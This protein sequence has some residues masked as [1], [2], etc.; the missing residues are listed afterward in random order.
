MYHIG[1][2][3]S[4]C[5]WMLSDV[6]Q[7]IENEFWA[8]SSHISVKNKQTNRQLIKEIIIFLLDQVKVCR[9]EVDLF[10]IQSLFK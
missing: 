6:N 7:T 2:P 4:Q 8:P 1:S 9:N 5:L 10:Q 3:Y